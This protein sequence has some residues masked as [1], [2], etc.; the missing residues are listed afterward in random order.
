[1]ASPSAARL[2][3]PVPLLVLARGGAAVAERDLFPRWSLWSYWGFGEPRFIFYPPGS[4]MSRG[5]AGRCFRGRLVPQAF[6]C[7]ALVA[8]GFSMYRLARETLDPRRRHGRACS[9]HSIPTR[10]SWS[11]DGARS[12]NC[13]RGVSPTARS[14]RRRVGEGRIDALVPLA[15]VARRHLADEHADGGPRD[16]RRRAASLAVFSWRAP[17]AARPLAR[18]RRGRPGPPPRG[19]LRDSRGPRDA[20]GHDRRRSSLRCS[21]PRTTIS[22]PGAPSA[23]GFQ[24]RRVARRRRPDRRPRRWPSLS[25]RPARDRAGVDRR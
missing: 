16:L 20:L 12:P 24:P 18:R 23:R 15:L 10:S 6:V 4:P 17:A 19:L 13:S 11:T 7:L 25:A 1:M 22:S 3:L 5:R 21:S 9:T 8:C 14:L 2:R